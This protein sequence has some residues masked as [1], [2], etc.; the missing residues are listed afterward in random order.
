MEESGRL[1]KLGER[2]EFEFAELNLIVR[3]THPE[4]VL[5]AAAEIIGDTEKL[6]CE[7]KI[8]QLSMLSEM[9][10]ADELDVD[11]AQFE[12]EQRFENVP[13]CLVS[14]G[15]TD[16]RWVSSVARKDDPPR[17]PPVERVHQMSLTRNDTFL[18]DSSKSGDD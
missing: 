3:G 4:W 15:S 13:Q 6:R 11:D 1:R 18:S 12:A 5:E 10:E 9:G 17:R 8:E 14:L 2:Y 16:Y 7:G